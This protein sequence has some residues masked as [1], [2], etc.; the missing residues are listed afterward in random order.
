MLTQIRARPGAADAAIVVLDP[1]AGFVSADEYEAHAIPA[2]RPLTRERAEALIAAPAQGE[3]LRALVT[4]REIDDVL[5][6]LQG[7]HLRVLD[8]FAAVLPLCRSMER[9]RHTALLQRGHLRTWLDRGHDGAANMGAGHIRW[10]KVI[11]GLTGKL[12]EF[13][14]RYAGPVITLGTRS[15]QS[16]SRSRRGHLIRIEVA[17]GLPATG[18]ATSAGAPL[19]HEIVITNKAH[20]RREIAAALRTFAGATRLMHAAA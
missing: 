11:H 10:G 18:Y 17:G 16:P 12:G 1:E 9:T 8:A 13:T 6:A 4:G 19:A 15:G 20:L 14:A 7:E 2:P 5:I 3:A